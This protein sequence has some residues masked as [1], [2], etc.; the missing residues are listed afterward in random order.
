M[1][2]PPLSGALYI[3]WNRSVGMLASATGPGPSQRDKAVAGDLLSRCWAV[4]GKAWWDMGKGVWVVSCPFPNGNQ[5]PA[6]K[7]T[8]LTASFVLRNWEMTGLVSS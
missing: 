1:L 5:S 7:G 4:E 3:S 2:L 8:P 6:G